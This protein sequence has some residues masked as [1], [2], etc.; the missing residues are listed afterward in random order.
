[1]KLYNNNNNNNNGNSENLGRCFI[2]SLFDT[3]VND[4]LLEI[5]DFLQKN[6]YD[7]KGLLQKG[8]YEDLKLKCALDSD[9]KINI[10][11]DI[12]L[13]ACE[14]EY[15]KCFAYFREFKNFIKAIDFVREHSPVE[16]VSN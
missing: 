13:F 9:S 14:D 15:V 2:K 6:F 8:F 10:N 4:V 7:K 1:M 3:F 11:H 12:Y 16:S 5:K